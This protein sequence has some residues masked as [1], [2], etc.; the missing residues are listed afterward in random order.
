M[1]LVSFPFNGRYMYNFWLLVKLNRNTFN[2]TLLRLDRS[3][4]MWIA[5]ESNW[6]FIAVFKVDIVGSL[7]LQVVSL[8]WAYT[9]LR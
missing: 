6:L 1:I 7:F 5:G 8:E 4:K 3:I 9:S 2:L